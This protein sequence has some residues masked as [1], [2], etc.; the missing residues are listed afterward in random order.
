MS[1]ASAQ[2]GITS[3]TIETLNTRVSV[4]KYTDAP[5]DDVT[6]NTLLNAARRTSTSSNTQT[7][8]FVVVRDAEKKRAL[9]ALSGNQQQVIDCPVFVA[10]CADVTR[11]NRAAAMHGETV[12]HSLELS[13]V[14]TI[15]A[16]IAGQSLALAAE[17][18][19]LGIVM[20]GGMRNHPQEAAEL[21]SLPD[22]AFVVFG[23]CIGWP[24]ET[25][26]QKPRLAPETVIHRERYRPATDA[27]LA[28]YDVALAAHYRTQGRATPDAAWTE[29]LA[30]RFRNV[31][32]AFLRAVLERRGFRFD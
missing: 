20:I 29:I 14:A 9:A 4:R 5:L 32:R 24:D 19:G 1:S 16:A 10:V 12:A 13:L 15:D 22:G 28:A 8:S 27:D 2:T 21:L 18:I 25:P 30:R 31:Q 6:L 23:L 7:Y 26:P 11:L 3:Q 17:S